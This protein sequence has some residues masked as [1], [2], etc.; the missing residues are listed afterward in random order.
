MTLADL[1]AAL[2]R[3]TGEP[4][5]VPTAA[6]IGPSLQARYRQ[7]KEATLSRLDMLVSGGDYGDAAV[8][9]V[10]ALLHKLAGTAAMFGEAEVG[11]RARV[12]EHELL[13]RPEAERAEKIAAA[14][15]QLRR[16]A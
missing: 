13:N 5:A 11:E 1:T 9:D 6:R 12:L 3:W 14:L 2:R 4:P 8:A 15:A 7:R 10:A 16:A